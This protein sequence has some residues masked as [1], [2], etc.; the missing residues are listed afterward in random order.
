M[1]FEMDEYIQS[2]VIEEIVYVGGGSG[3]DENDRYTVLQYDSQ[4]GEWS[5]LLPYLTYNFGMTVARNQ[6]VLVG[7][8]SDGYCSRFLGV[9]DT[10][11]LDWTHPY[12]DMKE[13][14]A[15]SSVVTFNEWLCVAG[16]RD[17]G[18]HNVPLVEIMNS[19]YNEWYTAAPIPVELTGMKTAIVGDTWYL[20]G[21]LKEDDFTDNVYSVFLPDLISQIDSKN[22]AE[23]GNIWRKISG[24]GLHSSTPFSFGGSLLALGGK[25]NN[26]LAAV[27]TIHQYTPAT[28]IWMEVGDLP[29]PWYDF[30]CVK[31]INN[32]IFVAGGYCHGNMTKITLCMS[33]NT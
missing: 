17:S 28:G 13:A 11:I 9:W 6:L 16:G 14:R 7:G 19:D 12:R 10:K 3:R 31:S 15:E 8:E 26:T 18:L 30:T 2:V 5:K 21:G 4:S 29:L 1:P 20:M 27:S 24:L 25:D 33:E 22:T 23:K 32:D